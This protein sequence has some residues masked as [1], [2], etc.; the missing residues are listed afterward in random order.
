MIDYLT[1]VIKRL[2]LLLNEVEWES[3]LINYHPPVVKR[4]WRQDGENRIYLHKIYPCKPEQAMKHTHGWPSAIRIISGVYEMQIGHIVNTDTGIYYHD[5][6][7]V[8][9][10][11]GSVY[12]LN[13]SLT[14]HS[15][16]PCEKPSLSV[17]VT[18]KPFME[19]PKQETNNPKNFKSLDSKEFNSLLSEFIEYFNFS[20]SIGS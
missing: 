11:P 14:W 8:F 16:S 4:L 17:M 20:D 19:A 1:Q 12:E 15:V 5:G 6:C 13:D 3:K 18:G 10:Y 2:P 9:L 7:R